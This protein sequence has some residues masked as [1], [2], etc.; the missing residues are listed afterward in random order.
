MKKQHEM[1]QEKQLVKEKSQNEVTE[2]V[3]L[4]EEHLHILQRL[5]KICYYCSERMTPQSI[6]MDCPVNS[7]KMLPNKCKNVILS[8]RILSE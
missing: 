7:M 3:K 4:S 2:W 5:Q 1:I 8:F 6:N